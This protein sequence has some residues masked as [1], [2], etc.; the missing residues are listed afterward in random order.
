M[1]SDCEK[2]QE[3]IRRGAYIDPSAEG[4]DEMAEHVAACPECAKLLKKIR[5]LEGSVRAAFRWADPGEGFNARV[6][7]AIAAP[8]RSSLFWRFA[9]LAA[10][11]AIVLAVLAAII[12][13]RPSG[14]TLRLARISG[15][16][17][18]AKG[19][20]VARSIPI[21]ADVVVPESQV[22]LEVVHGVGLA[23]RP[24]SVFRILPASTT[25]YTRLDLK[26]GGAAISVKTDAKADK[27]EVGLEGFSILTSDADF[28]VETRTNGALPGLY[29]DRGRVVVS[30]GGGV[31][32]VER[33]EHVELV[34][35][36]LLSRVRSGEA[37]IKADLAALDAHC[38]DLQTQIARYEAMVQTYGVRRRERND[39]LVM[40]QEALTVAPDQETARELEK[41]ISK[42]MAAVENLDFVM[43]EHIAKMSTLRGELP[44]RLNELRR[45]RAMAMQQREK[46]KAGLALLAGLR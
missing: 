25:G 34:A 12:T 22:A 11:A 46:C 24:H 2:C 18:L 38:R 17:T 4:F 45:K 43:G 40:A 30:F 28:L 31:S 26:R 29:V 14:D 19:G 3:L 39:E 13:G 5:D 37:R 21:D 33:G 41:R 7:R 20:E 44:K 32:V 10:A 16:L 42:E 15:E 36:Q 8:P 23:L 1:K 27:L 9:P 35:D 6:M